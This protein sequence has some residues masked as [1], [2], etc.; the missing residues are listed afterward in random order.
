M[1][2]FL[3]CN[4]NV[5]HKPNSHTVVNKGQKVLWSLSTV[6]KILLLKFLP[7]PH[8]AYQL[9]K[10]KMLYI[11]VFLVERTSPVHPAEDNEL[12]GY[13][14]CLACNMNTRGLASSVP[15]GFVAFLRKRKSFWIF[16][17]LFQIPLQL[18]ALWQR[19]IYQIP[20]WLQEIESFNDFANIYF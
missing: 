1:F 7:Q 8:E 19:M 16:C 6:V 15:S 10:N 14:N 17:S 13:L 3:R 5:A 4:V 18:V 2:W 20:L 11:G 9:W 12:G